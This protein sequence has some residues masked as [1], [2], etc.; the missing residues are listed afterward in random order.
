MIQNNDNNE[1]EQIKKENRL[2]DELA[3]FITQ[4]KHHVEPQSRSSITNLLENLISLVYQYRDKYIE[5]NKEY[6][7]NKLLNQYKANGEIMY[8]IAEAYYNTGNKK[9]ALEWYN[10]AF[11]N[12][13]HGF[14]RMHINE[15]KH[16]IEEEKI[17]DGNSKSTMQLI[18]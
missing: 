9:D 17:N 2:L 14:V 1:K 18:G 12:T 3:V 16:L 13:R 8:L 11:E 10:C 7:A 6:E 15:R 5:L 4:Y